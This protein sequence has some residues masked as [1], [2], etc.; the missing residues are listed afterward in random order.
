MIK[1]WLVAPLLISVSL[2]AHATA[3]GGPNCGWGNMLF[4]GSTG[5]GPHMVALTTNGTSGN[6][7]FGMTSGTNGCDTSTPLSYG[8]ER[9]SFLSQMMDNFSTD[10]ARGEGETLEA[11]AVV[12]GV[13]NQDKAHFAS[14]LH[15][16]FDTLFPH[17]DVTADSVVISLQNIMN[18]DV[19]VQKYV[20]A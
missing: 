15:D 9:V 10:V 12:V 2:S 7:T 18:N 16:N 20:S 4:E 3:P 8:G 11:F 19:V 1:K 14:V 6:Q 13:E 5:I 17:T